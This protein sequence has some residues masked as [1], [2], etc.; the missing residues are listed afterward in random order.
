MHEEEVSV[1]T[2]Y[3][4]NHDLPM[5]VNLRGYCASKRATLE[6]HLSRAGILHNI[7]IIIVV[8]G[9]EVLNGVSVSEF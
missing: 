9:F 1:G 4:T 3:H 5:E 7:N 2:N 6:E 8:V